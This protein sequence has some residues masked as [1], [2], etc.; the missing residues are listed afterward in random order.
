MRAL[1]CSGP[2][3]SKP[4][5]S[6]S[7][8]AAALAPLV[9][10]GD[11]ELVDDDLRAVGE[12][13]ELRLP[14][15]PSASG[16]DRV[17][18]LEAERGVLREH[19]V[20]EHERRLVVGEVVERARTRARS[21]LVDEHAVALAE[22]AAPR[23]LAREAHRRALEHER[24]ERERLGERPVDLV[25]RRTSVRRACSWRSSFGLTVKSSGHARERVDDLRRARRGC[26]AGRRPR[27]RRARRG[28]TRGVDA[29][30]R[31]ARRLACVSSNA[32]V[33]PGA[34]VGFE[35]RFSS[36]GV[37]SPRLHELLGVE[38]R[39]PTAVRV[40]EL[41][42]PRLRERGLV[43]LVV[44]VAAV[45]DEVDDDVLVERLAELEREPH[46]P[47]RA[48]SGSSPFTWKIGACTILATSVA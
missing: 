25:A 5:G 6:S 3:P 10:G 27:S 15:R 42:H 13:A 21:S 34:E 38:R 36:S 31:A 14:A 44:A 43:G 18:V 45:A 46:R 2:W 48:A 20:V 9:L 37:M 41:V 30:A 22:R 19:G 12:V 47:A 16:H 11:D 24:A 32:C 1:E 40:D 23:V 17:A 28:R 8:E 29:S 26:T 4:W 7:D 39:A 35:R 33:E